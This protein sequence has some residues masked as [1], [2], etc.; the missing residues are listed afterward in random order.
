MTPGL[1]QVF[2]NMKEELSTK[3]GVFET[4]EK[5]LFGVAYKGDRLLNCRNNQL[6]GI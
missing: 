6:D 1:I 3:A 5:D 4:G 2:I